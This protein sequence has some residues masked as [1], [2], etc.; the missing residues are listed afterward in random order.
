MPQ[1]VEDTMMQACRF[2]VLP[3]VLLSVLA[4]SSRADEAEG[5]AQDEKGIEVFCGP[6]EGRRG[7]KVIFP[8]E[9]RATETDETKVTFKVVNLLEE[10]V[11]LEVTGIE[12]LDYTLSLDSN[13]DTAIVSE[14][15][16]GTEVIFPDNTKLLKRLHATTYKDEE[17]FTCG[18]AIAR[19]TTTFRCED[20]A[21]WIGATGT[22]TLN[23]SGYK[24]SDGA[25]FSKT[26]DVP[27]SIVE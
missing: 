9:I 10:Q 19:I 13:D 20:F 22:I 14:V 11:F 1:P 26:V 18:C 15:L 4:I 23:I 25:S 7:L 3:I 5:D 16:G 21:S 6:V 27:I 8:A 2:V 24:R 12:I 17:S